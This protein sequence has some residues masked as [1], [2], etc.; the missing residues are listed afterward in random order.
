LGF[1]KDQ[2]GSFVRHGKAE[3]GSREFLKY[4]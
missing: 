4:E 1:Y 3:N 2:P